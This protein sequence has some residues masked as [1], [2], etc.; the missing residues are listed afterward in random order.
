PGGAAPAAPATPVKA[1]QAAAPHVVAATGPTPTVYPAAVPYLT[2]NGGGG[3][4][5][6]VQDRS[7]SNPDVATGVNNAYEH[8][9]QTLVGNY[10]LC[11]GAP[12]AAIPPGTPG[13][14][15]LPPAA[16]AGSFWALHGADLLGRPAPSIAPGYALAGKL[17]YLETHAATTRQFPNPTPLGPLNI[18][19]RAT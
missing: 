1:P 8:R 6:A 15:A 9:W 14:P 4:C 7:T 3:F 12:Q 16:V 13:A 2:D 5:I 19:A 18:A 10:L 11:P 17:G